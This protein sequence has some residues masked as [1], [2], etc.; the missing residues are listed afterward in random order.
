MTSFFKLLPLLSEVATK[1]RLL[2]LPESGKCSV[3]LC[4]NL[5]EVYFLNEK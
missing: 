3:E 5:Q 1:K 4:V 2:N